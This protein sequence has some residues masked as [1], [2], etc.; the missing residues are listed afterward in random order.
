MGSHLTQ[1]ITILNSDSSRLKPLLAHRVDNGLRICVCNIDGPNNR[2][3][4]IFLKEQIIIKLR[5]LKYRIICERWLHD[6]DACFHAFNQKFPFSVS[7]N[8]CVLTG[9]CWFDFKCPLHLWFQFFALFIFLVS[10][11]FYFPFTPIHFDV[12]RWNLVRFHNVCNASAVL[13]QPPIR[14]CRSFQNT[15]PTIAAS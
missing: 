13:L 4:Q 7:L 5:S 2:S 15:K 9:S 11:S 12:S 8:L 10:F 14:S 1:Y 3:E 6:N